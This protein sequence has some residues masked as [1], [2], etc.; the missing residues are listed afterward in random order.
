MRACAH[1]AIASGA[2]A[3]EY[4]PFSGYHNENHAEAVTESEPP[5]CGSRISSFADR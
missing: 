5:G 2:L 3:Q 1:L 4:L